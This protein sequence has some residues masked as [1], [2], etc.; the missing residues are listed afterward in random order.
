MTAVMPGRGTAVRSSEGARRAGL[1]VIIG[2]FIVLLRLSYTQLIAP[3][4]GYAGY[5]FVPPSM[6]LEAAMVVLAMAPAWLLPLQLT[7]P[8]QYTLWFLYPVVVIP[9]ILIPTYNAT[10]PWLDLVALSVAILCCF[11]LLVWGTFFPLAQWPRLA[12]PPSLFWTG[13]IG[14]V[15][16]T[17][18]V[19]H[20]IFGIPVSIPSLSQVYQR[21]TEFQD[22]VV[23]NGTGVVYL[24]L[25]LANVINPLLM[26]R[27]L[28]EGKWAWGFLGLA[29]QVVVF[30]IGG[31]KGVFLA[32][33]L[34]VGIAI[35]LVDGGSRFGLRFS[36]A[37]LGVAGLGLLLD[38]IL[39]SNLIAGLLVRRVIVTPGLLTGAYVQYFSTHPPAMLG[40]S[41]LHGLAEN[42]YGRGPPQVIGD[43]LAPGQSLWAN[44]NFWAD[45]FAN[46]GYGGMFVFTLLLALV[47]WLY[48][49]LAAGKRIGITVL[50][51]AMPT[52]SL[53]NSSLLTCLSTHGLGL[54][55]LVVA[56]LPAA[57][58]TPILTES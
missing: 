47:L 19:I 8:S 4:Y 18:V 10:L 5:A 37:F 25:W 48:D 38:P 36:L 54:A 26:A 33:V 7:R 46:F 58:P 32:P 56:L 22:T 42:V 41:V 24:S 30:S 1:L 34:M 39:P 11:M 35:L 43:Y 14:F 16:M 44:A 12:L 21:R 6:A 51:L 15:A 13:T 2:G 3:N 9:A 28:T 50:I 40:Y 53:T 31:F 20:S 45:A 17:L 49:S 29:G 57:V 52:F 23:A 27:G 55:L